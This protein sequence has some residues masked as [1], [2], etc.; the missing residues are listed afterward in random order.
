MG[1]GASTGASAEAS[2]PPPGRGTPGTLYDDGLPAEAFRDGQ[3]VVHCVGPIWG[4]HEAKAKAQAWLEKEGKKHGCDP[5]GWVFTG[6]WNSE[7]GTSYCQYARVR[8]NVCVGPIWGDHEAA[9]KVHAFM[10]ATGVHGRLTWTNNWFSEAGT[11]YA[12]FFRPNPVDVIFSFASEDMARVG[13]IA[14]KLY[15]NGQKSCHF[16]NAT[17]KGFEGTKGELWWRIEWEAQCRVSKLA[18]TFETPTYLAKLQKQGACAL[19]KHCIQT[20]APGG[21]LH[22][23]ASAGADDACINQ[24]L[25]FLG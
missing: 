4:N 22:W 23:D 6:Q 13:D 1:G 5:F 24:I 3:T 16:Y 20:E 25:A 2:A 12:Q 19:E 18:V 14:N 15:A 17:S 9:E 10:E 11:S 8:A 7:N 21:K